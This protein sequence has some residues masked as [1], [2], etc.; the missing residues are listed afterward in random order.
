MPSQADVDT[1]VRVNEYCMQTLNQQDLD[2]NFALA[3]T[4]LFKWMQAARM[5]LPWLQPGY[6]A[7]G[8]LEPQMPRRLLLASQIFRGIKPGVLAEAADNSVSTRCEIGTIGKTSIEFRYKIFF[9]D[10]LIGH[11]NVTMI[12]VAGTPGNLKPSPVPEA[13]RG[14]GA[15]E[16]DETKHFMSDHLAA[17]PKEPPADAYMT[18]VVVRYS[19][20]DLNKH[21]NH[22]AAARFFEDSKEMLAADESANPDLRAIAQQQLQSILI[23]YSAETRANDQLTV[24]V[25]TSAANTLDVWIHRKN[26]NSFGGKPGLVNRGRMICGG[27]SVLDSEALRLKAKL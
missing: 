1:T 21:A 12:V 9:G 13:V 5:D 4:H 14:L 16:P 25:A 10:R 3:T 23:S 15:V 22:S 18:S 20:E 24:S 7:L 27:G 8:W 19:D 26:S 17:L 11:G 6:R 2:R